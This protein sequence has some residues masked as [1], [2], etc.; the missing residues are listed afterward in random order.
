MIYQ[1]VTVYKLSFMIIP[2]YTEWAI[3]EIQ[4]FHPISQRVYEL[5]V[6]ILLKFMLF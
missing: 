4:P 6:Q 2:A 1:S 3:S 5:M